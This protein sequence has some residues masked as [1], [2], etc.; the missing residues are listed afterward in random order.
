MKKRNIT[1]LSLYFSSSGLHAWIRKKVLLVTQ[2]LFK[3]VYAAIS[4]HCQAKWP[5]HSVNGSLGQLS[6]TQSLIGQSEKFQ[7]ATVSLSC[8]VLSLTHWEVSACNCFTVTWSVVSYSII[9]KYDSER[10]EYAIVSCT[11]MWSVVSNSIINWTEWEVCACNC[12]TALS[13]E[14][15]SLTQSSMEQSE[16]FAHATVPLHCHVKCCL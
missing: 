6:L 5:C 3:C 12:S 1:S 15:F 7:H 10:F 16:M 14:V 9:N 2:C 13:C 8:E 4:L 11:V